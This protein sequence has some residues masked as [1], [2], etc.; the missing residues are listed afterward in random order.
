MYEYDQHLL[1]ELCHQ[2][3]PW[4]HN[5]I[6]EDGWSDLKDLQMIF[7]LNSQTSSNFR[8]IA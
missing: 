8:L 7:F 4:P 3:Q 6:Q 2:T 5:C 1:A